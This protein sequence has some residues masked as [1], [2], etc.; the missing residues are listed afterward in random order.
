M[1]NRRGRPRKDS[2][3]EN[4][5]AAHKPQ[6]EPKATNFDESCIGKRLSRQ[7]IISKASVLI[8]NPS[9]DPSSDDEDSDDFDPPVFRESR[10]VLPNL[11]PTLVAKPDNSA[12][13]TAPPRLTG[14]SPW[15]APLREKA[16]SDL[17]MLLRKSNLHQSLQ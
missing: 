4:P 3:P 8:E 6:S 10:S 17:R 7:K 13:R 14:P 9:S 5:Q 1:S 15:S 12:P 11:K 2:A 16:W